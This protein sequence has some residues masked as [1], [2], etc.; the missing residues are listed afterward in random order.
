VSSKNVAYVTAEK[1][2]AMRACA[3]APMAVQSFTQGGSLDAYPHLPGLHGRR[4]ARS[5][6]LSSPQV[7]V[8]RGSTNDQSRGHGAVWCVIAG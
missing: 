4:S 1:Q 6:K 7:G 3:L 8:S 2:A 5:S